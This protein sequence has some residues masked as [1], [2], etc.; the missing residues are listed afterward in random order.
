MPPSMRRA[1]FL[2]GLSLTACIVQAPTSDGTQASAPRPPPAPPVEVK[3]GANFG[4]KVELTSVVLSPS[5]IYTGETL[6]VA[7]NFKV[8]API[9]RD[10]LIFVHVED[11]E[12]RVDRLNVD[13]QPRAKPTSQW[14]PGELVRDE[15]EV[16]VPAGMPVKALSLILGLWDPR[17]DERMPLRNKDVVKND[18]RDRLFVA[19]IPVAQP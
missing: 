4:D 12:G 13:H 5:R 9:D 8:L 19:T 16:P 15:F 10:Y 18:G 14:Q 2:F 17:S 1:L 11:V 7:L 6:R 3:S